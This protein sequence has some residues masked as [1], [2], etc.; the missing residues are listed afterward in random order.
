[1][2]ASLLPLSSVFWSGS[3]LCWQRQ[4]LN[5][6][7][8]LFPSRE[9]VTL[10]VPMRGMLRPPAVPAECPQGVADAIQACM[11]VRSRFAWLSCLWEL[12]Q[13]GQGCTIGPNMPLFRPPHLARS[14]WKAA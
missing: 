6:T 10:E 14:H 5:P 2:P 9:L 4:A 13:L 3:W 12:V 1:M 11:Q 8:T 7:L